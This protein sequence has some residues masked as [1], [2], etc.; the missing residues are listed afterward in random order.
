MGIKLVIY[1]M[2]ITLRENRT[3]CTSNEA[4]K[5]VRLQAIDSIDKQSK[6][7]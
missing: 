3:L 6:Q 2:L 1:G 5:M 7:W 4:S